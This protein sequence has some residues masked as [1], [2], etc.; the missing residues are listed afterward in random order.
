MVRNL[1]GWRD[2]ENSE[3]NFWDGTDSSL[4]QSVVQREGKRSH[5][6]LLAFA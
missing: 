5:G 3:V 2:M 4:V 1:V 6:G